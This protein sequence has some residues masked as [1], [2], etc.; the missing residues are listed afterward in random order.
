MP[1]VGTKTNIPKKTTLLK[2]TN[3][4]KVSARLKS[5]LLGAG[6]LETHPSKHCLFRT[7]QETAGVYLVVKGRV[8]LSLPDLPK[9]DRTFTPGSLLGLP[10]TF[11][12]NAYSLDAISATEV[13]VLHVERTAFLDLMACQPEFCREAANILSREVT[14][15]QGALAERR[16]I[17][18]TAA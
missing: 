9:L 7:D 4:L 8:C 16:R 14:F 3:V 18:F 15:I 6:T 2:K 13:E 10:A 5:L 1:N 17:K 12:G 11:T